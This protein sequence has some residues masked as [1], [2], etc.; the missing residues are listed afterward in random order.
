MFNLIEITA[1]EMW[2]LLPTLWIITYRN[3]EK[4]G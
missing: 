4:G 3:N 1:R 2:K